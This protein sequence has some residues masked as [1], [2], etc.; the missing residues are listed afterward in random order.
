MMQPY[1]KSEK[2]FDILC[3]TPITHKQ[4]DAFPPNFVHSLD[5][6]HMMLTTLYCRKR[7]VTFAA[8]HDCFWTH[9]SDVDVMNEICREQ[10]IRLHSQ[11]IVE[12]LGEVGM[13]IVNSLTF[14]GVQQF[15]NVYLSKEEMTK[16]NPESFEKFRRSFT[17]SNKR[18]TLDIEQIRDSVYFFS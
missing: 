18:G 13:F 3:H 9:A 14:R 2:R 1:L 10:F 5:S 6:T 11:P 15:R 17:P 7:G 8:V 12:N 4:V 16:M